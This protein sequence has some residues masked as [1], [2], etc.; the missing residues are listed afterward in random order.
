MED[1]IVHHGHRRTAGVVDSRGFKTKKCS[2]HDDNASHLSVRSIPANKHVSV[3][4][5]VARGPVAETKRRKVYY[6]H[7]KNTT[8]K[9]INVH[10]QHS[11][12]V[13]S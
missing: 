2:R 6:K 1:P 3:A 10:G 9:E 8:P 7:A 12:D 11:V 4:G 5:R 13:S